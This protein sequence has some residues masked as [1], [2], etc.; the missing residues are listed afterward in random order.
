[1]EKK[2]QT[3]Q[4]AEFV[5]AVVQSLPRDMDTN[6]AQGWITNRKGL[7]KVLWE[8]LV[9]PVPQE[10]KSLLTFVGTIKVRT[11][12]KFSEREFFQ[13]NTKN[14]AL[15]RISYITDNFKSWFFP[16]S[17]SE[18]ADAGSYRKL[19]DVQKKSGEV[20]LRYHTLKHYVNKSIIDRL[21]GEAK[22]K[23]TLMEIATCMQKQANGE[24]GALLTDDDYANI[25]CVRDVNGV[26][27]TVGVG[28]YDGGW[29]IGA[30]SVGERS[31]GYAGG[32]IFSR[33]F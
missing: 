11:T 24:Q 23:I 2:M 31:V 4:F 22:A 18:D 8:T 10:P 9:P 21:G 12:K 19:S 5:A 6:T 30:N 29:C 13:T 27:R 32:R 17:A 7:A 3:D 15:A 26:L 28:W 16:P 33:D 14:N 25:F 20:A 1:M